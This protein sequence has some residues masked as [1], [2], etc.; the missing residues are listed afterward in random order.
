MSRASASLILIVV[1]IGLAIY[2]FIFPP[3]GF[4]DSLA[5]R[6]AIPFLFLSA[7]FCAL[8]NMRTRAHIGQLVGALRTLMARAG[9]E[10]AP[11]VKGEAV[12]IL[13]HSLRTEKS[14]VR[15]VVVH[16][17]QNLTGQSIGNDPD[18][19]DAWWKENRQSFGKK[20]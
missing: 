4:D 5:Y 8:E 20:S 9:K 10:P 15:E 18:R 6:I 2:F 17:L 16:Q 14:D 1:M 3:R 13:L 12:E 7:A 19:W 11:E